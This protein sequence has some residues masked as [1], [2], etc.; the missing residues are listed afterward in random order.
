MQDFIDFLGFL[1]AQFH[2][3]EYERLESMLEPATFSGIV[4]E[5]MNSVIPNYC[6]TLLRN[7]CHNAHPDPIPVGRYPGDAAQHG[8]E[9]IEVKGSRNVGQWQGHNPERSWLM[10]FIF[11]SSRPSDPPNDVLPRPFRFHADLCAQME[12]ER[13]G[14]IGLAG[15]Q[16]RVAG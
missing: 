4:G 16:P 14:R 8:T 13:R 9:G 6:P 2:S 1:N 10:V 15:W 5:F 11:G 12:V 3:K 7:R